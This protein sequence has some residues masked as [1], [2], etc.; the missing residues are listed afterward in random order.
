MNDASESN[1]KRASSRV[2]ESVRSSEKSLCRIRHANVN[3]RVHIS[4][5]EKS[6]NAFIMASVQMVHYIYYIFAESSKRGNALV[7]MR[8]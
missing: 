1:F 2:P 3:V 6:K 7:P 8:I 5:V 4:M